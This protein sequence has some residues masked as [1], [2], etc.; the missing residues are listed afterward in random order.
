MPSVII[1]RLG[2]RVEVYRILRIIARLLIFRIVCVFYLRVVQTLVVLI[3][4]SLDG[5]D[6]AT[7]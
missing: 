6:A 4:R 1:F 5:R 2:P 3:E 7:L